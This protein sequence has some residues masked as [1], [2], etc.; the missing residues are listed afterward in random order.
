VPMRRLGKEADL[1]GAILL[2]S[3]DASSWMTGEVITVDGGHLTSPL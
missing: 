1:D 3:T 2:L